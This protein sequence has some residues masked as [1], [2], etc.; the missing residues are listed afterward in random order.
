MPGEAVASWPIQPSAK[1]AFKTVSPE[2]RHH[3]TSK[4]RPQLSSKKR[5]DIINPVELVGLVAE[6]DLRKLLK[7]KG[8]HSWC[9]RVRICGL[10][11]LINHA[12]RHQKKGEVGISGE[13]AR[14]FVSKIRN[15]F[16]AHVI[17]EPLPLL[18]HI[19]LF[20]LVR[21]GV[22]AHVQAPAVYAVGEEYIGRRL[23]LRVQLTPK[24]AVKFATAEQRLE[25][26][27]N[28]K[29]PYRP[30]LLQ[31]LNAI[32]ID[33]PGRAVMA[34][35]NRTSSKDAATTT[36][37]AIDGRRHS[38]KTSPRGQITTSISSCPRELQPHLLLSGEGVAFCDI[39]NAHWYFL[40][41]VLAERLRKISNQP[42]REQYLRDGWREHDRLTLLLCG[43]DFY[44]RWCADPENET[45]RDQK[46]TVLN[47]LLNQPLERCH[48]NRLYR[49]VKRQFPITFGVVENI[50][51]DDYRNIGVQLHRFMAEV[52][53]S[54]LLEIQGQSIAAIPL[55][56]ALICQQRH[57]A[58][59]CRAIGEQVFAST[60]VCANVGGIRYSPLTEEEEAA[61]AFD[62][63]AASNDGMSY[64]EWDAVRTL[65]CV[66]ALKL[67]RRSPRFVFRCYARAPF[68]EAGVV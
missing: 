64:D 66:A 62:D 60:G 35:L 51:R 46:K 36:M 11:L 50:K 32:S 57:H 18:C 55:V 12:L 4:K 68:A 22:H 65:K 5:H 14:S 2:K 59:V 44:R 67:L 8:Q 34:D 45:E 41:K 29:Y 3:L 9:S 56:D 52:I 30:R 37:T 38:V 6:G 42:N 24:M 27:L 20:R 13:L 19:G 26:R 10:L 23:Q 53:S 39:S 25:S 40:P 7:A 43:E 15:G 17:K 54:A 28:R 48:N 1:S 58:T 49:W 33:V 61:L 16:P 31:D 63:E 47:I 21:P